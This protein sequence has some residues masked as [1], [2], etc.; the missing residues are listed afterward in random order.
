[1][2]REETV[3]IRTGTLG[4]SST[5]GVVGGL[6]GSTGASSGSSEP[7]AALSR[8]VRISGAAPTAA[9]YLRNDRRDSL[10]GESADGSDTGIDSCKGRG[11]GVPSRP[12]PVAANARTR[13]ASEPVSVF[14]EILFVLMA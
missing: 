8:A 11:V 10:H 14:I 3:S 4:N 2:G 12:L 7:L 13:P 6:G 1:V 5:H 9:A